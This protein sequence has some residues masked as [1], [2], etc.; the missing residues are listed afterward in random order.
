MDT[1]TSP[2]RLRLERLRSAM[3]QH[4]L[5]AL[6]VPSSDPHLSEYLPERWQGREWL[7]GFTGSMG[8]LVV[9]QA[10]GALFADSRY[11][12]QAERQLAGKLG[13]LLGADEGR[14]QAREPALLHL[15]QAVVE[16]GRRQEIQHGVA[17]EFE[18]LVVLKNIGV[19]VQIGAMC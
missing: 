16:Q 8:T 13:Q 11:W 5:D 7:S 1:R 15:R 6:L 19:F 2:Q 14:P 18:T 17:Q 4:G 9:T 12:G 10:G 3:Q